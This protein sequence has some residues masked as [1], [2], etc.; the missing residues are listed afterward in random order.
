MVSGDS[1]KH[2]G[3]AQ[4]AMIIVMVLATAEAMLRS[5]VFVAARS[6]VDDLGSCC[7]CGLCWY[8]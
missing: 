4:K 3:Q 8:I 2:R 5:L 6:H 1:V 7:H